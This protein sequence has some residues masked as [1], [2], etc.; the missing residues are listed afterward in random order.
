MRDSTSTDAPTVFPAWEAS[1]ALGF[2][3]D[4]DTTRLVR[5][6]HRG[7]LRV[8]KALYPEGPGACHVIVVH[9]PGGVVGGDRL[10]IDVDAGPACSVLATSPGAAKW[11]RAN[12]R[13]SQQAV[14]L[15]IAAGA[16][17][18]WL[19]QETIFYDAASV[20][21][22]H[23][24][25]L[26]AGSTYIGSEVL[27]FGRVAAGEA[28][29]RG[30][31]RQRTR[32][33]QEGRLLWWE[34]GILTPDGIASPLGMRGHAVCA[35]LLAVGR[36]VPAALQAHVRALDPQLASS[37]VKSVFVVRYLGDDG[38]AARAVMAQVWALLRPHLLDRPACPPRIWLT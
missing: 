9:P 36:P 30:R 17:I 11:Y 16:A 12:G 29:T 3:R 26:T 4:G 14:R 2:V 10:E 1:L 22:D 20:D 38:E 33:R 5:R 34:Q 24:V 18:E 35:T 37:Q 31:I 32:I 27:C 7:P 8:Q 28:F 23:D 6:T 13:V 15:R 25:D 19:P 21:L